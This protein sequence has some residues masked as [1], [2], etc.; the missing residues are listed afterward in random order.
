MHKFSSNQTIA[1]PLM[2]IIISNSDHQPKFVIPTVNFTNLVTSNNNIEIEPN[3]N[4]LKMEHLEHEALG[5]LIE[6]DTSNYF[7]QSSCILIKILCILINILFKHMQAQ[8]G[9]VKMSFIQI[10][11]LH[12]RLCS[13]R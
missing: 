6:N 2:Q 1:R 3:P 8:E 10:S 13:I 7:S 4:V 11:C 5:I 12:S 9:S